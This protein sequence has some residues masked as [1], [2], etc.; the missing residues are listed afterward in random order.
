MIVSE[1]HY[2]IIETHP[3]AEQLKE[4][5]IEEIDNCSDV[6]DASLGSEMTNMVAKKIFLT[7]SLSNPS[8]QILKWI[9]DIVVFTHSVGLPSGVSCDSPE[10]VTTYQTGMWV[11]RYGKGHYCKSHSHYP[12]LFSF[13][14]FIKCPPKSSPLIFTTSGEEISAEEGKVVIFPSMLKHHV[15][16]NHSEDRIILSGNMIPVR[17][18]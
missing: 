18:V 17:Q 13:V 1:N 12:S 14:Y 16:Y 9:N 15:P 4:K 3:R 6:L 7:P 10:A 5:L 8:G 2:L 11:G